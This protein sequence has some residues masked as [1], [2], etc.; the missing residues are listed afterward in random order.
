M[1]LGTSSAG[2]CLAAGH[3]REASR[4]R[5][6]GLGLPRIDAIDPDPRSLAAIDH[7]RV[8]APVTTHRAGLAEV[9][10][11][12]W[13]PDRGA[14]DLVDGAGRFDCLSDAVAAALHARLLQRDAVEGA[15]QVTSGLPGC[16]TRGHMGCFMD[17]S[18]GVPHPRPARG[19]R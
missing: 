19:G 16:P 12:T 1:A 3:L 7:D 11:R 18:R 10:Q 2:L 17:W 15:L 14:D 9:L 6:M 13:E 5:Q 8:G 4:V